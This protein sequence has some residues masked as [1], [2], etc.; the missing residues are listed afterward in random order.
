MPNYANYVR[1]R[2]PTP[3]DEDEMA[4]GFWGSSHLVPSV[5]EQCASTLSTF[6][7]SIDC[8]LDMLLWIA[9]FIYRAGQKDYKLNP[10]EER[11]CREQL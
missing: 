9:S 7:L 5:C 6:V 2:M 10:K 1:V 8:F 4:K 3:C 11:L